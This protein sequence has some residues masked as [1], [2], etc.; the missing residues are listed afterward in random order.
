MSLS[1]LITK[2]NLLLA[3]R[4]ITASRD[5]RYK[6]YFRP[7]LE[8][9]ELS[10]D[11]NIQDL[12][13]RIKND[14]YIPQPSIRIYKPKPSG[15]QRPLSLL[16]IEDQIVLQATTNLVAEKIRKRRANLENLFVFSN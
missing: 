11:K 13:Q 8:A 12:R 16:Y 14:I 2:K 4:R 15:L 6:N 10:L 7:A 9:Y 3:W 1:P 5:A